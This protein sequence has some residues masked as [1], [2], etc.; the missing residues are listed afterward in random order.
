MT[1]HE[2]AK[3]KRRLDELAARFPSREQLVSELTDLH[4]MSDEELRIWRRMLKRTL[5]ERRP[6]Q[7]SNEQ[8]AQVVEKF[9]TARLAAI[10]CLQKRNPSI[11]RWN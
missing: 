8:E 6:L 4:C 10:K 5:T 1:K 11:D 7:P 3:I 2:S 9:K